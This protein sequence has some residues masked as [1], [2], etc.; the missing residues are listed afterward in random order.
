MANLVGLMAVQSAEN[1]VSS[2]I[3]SIDYY[4]RAL[5]LVEPTWNNP[6]FDPLDVPHLDN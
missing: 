5:T 6:I 3:T 4:L 2:K 1:K